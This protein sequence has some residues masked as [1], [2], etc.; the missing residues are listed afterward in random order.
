MSEV[1]EFP[2]SIGSQ[3]QE[4]AGLSVQAW[5]ALGDTK[6]GVPASSVHLPQGAFD[7]NSLSFGPRDAFDTD[8]DP[9][10]DDDPADAIKDPLHDPNSS[11]YWNR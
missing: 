8:I 2:L 10:P 4:P 1:H 9:D 11:R 3:T 6:L 7:G 5:Q